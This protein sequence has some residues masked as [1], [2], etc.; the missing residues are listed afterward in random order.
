IFNITYSTKV[1]TTLEVLHSSSFEKQ[2][3]S[4]A[5]A[6]KR[7]LNGHNLNNRAF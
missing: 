2:S 7:F 6:A 3:F 4:L 1:R 5:L